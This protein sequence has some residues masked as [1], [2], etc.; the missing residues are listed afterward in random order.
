MT[1]LI[2]STLYLAA[3]LPLVVMVGRVLRRCSL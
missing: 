3:A 2:A 1:L